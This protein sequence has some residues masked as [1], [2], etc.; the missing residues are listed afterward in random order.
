[1]V[2]DRQK[3]LI[4]F[5]VNRLKSIQGVNALF[6]KGS[7]G[8][9]ESDKYSD[10]DFYCI[11]EERIFD[12]M[13]LKREDILKEYR[14]ILYN[15]KVNFGIP[16]IIVIY[17]NNLHLDFYLTKEVPK[18]GTDEIMSLYD[19]D[20]VLNRYKRI[21][22][23]TENK[24]IISYLNSAIYTLHE[25]EIA[26][27]RKDILWTTRLASHMLADLSL[28]LSFMYDKEKPVLHMKRLQSKLPKHTNDKI[29]LI[30]ELMTPKKLKDCVLNLINLCE[31]II[32][33]QK[34]EIKKSLHIKYL[35][36]MYNK[37]KEL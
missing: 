33:E 10:V 8:R 9:K 30:L 18:E 16:Q 23:I 19:P 34:S 28:V 31:G 1:M 4:D 14:P 27:R 22:N 3:E 5:L 6:V 24:E 20:N 25:I 15:E 36:Y 12:D 2:C 26:Y 11:V 7:I 21:R 32:N 13:M 17:D 29:Q 37:I 35:E